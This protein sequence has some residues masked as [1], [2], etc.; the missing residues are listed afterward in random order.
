MWFFY[1]HPLLQIVA[2]LFGSYAVFLGLKRFLNVF[3]QFGSNFNWKH[4]V[5]AGQL[6]LEDWLAG[7]ILG[8][9]VARVEWGGWFI[10]GLHAKIAMV[11]LPMICFGL[12]SG[13]YMNLKPCRRK[14]LPLAHGFNNICIIVLVLV[15]IVVGTGV[16]KEFVLGL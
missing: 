8:T 10:T 4:H 15:Q 14:V 2:L 11:L 9:V 16:F 5:I 6:A 7:M 3:F 1:I 13:L 12:V